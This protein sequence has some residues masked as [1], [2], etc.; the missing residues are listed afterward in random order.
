M[1]LAG[2][3]VLSIDGGKCQGH[4]RCY[5]LAPQLVDV[6]EWGQ[7]FVRGDG[8]VP[9]ELHDKAALLVANCPEFAIKLN[10][11]ERKTLE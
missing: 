4:N 3:L 1:S 6:D 10:R 8:V 7:A 2:I 9:T 11:M 5:A